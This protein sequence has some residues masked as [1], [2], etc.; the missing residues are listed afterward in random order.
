MRLICLKDGIGVLIFEEEGIIHSVK[1]KRGHMTANSQPCGCFIFVYLYSVWSNGLGNI[2]PKSDQ[3]I[4]SP[5]IKWLCQFRALT[6]CFLM[7][8]P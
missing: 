6:S 3:Q 1:G 5:I 4:M 8:R 2:S 7:K